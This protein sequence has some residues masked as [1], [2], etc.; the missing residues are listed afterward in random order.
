VG[1]SCLP[2]QRL[3][4]EKEK[5]KKHVC[6]LL[7]YFFSRRLKGEKHLIL[8]EVTARGL[9]GTY[10]HPSDEL[11]IEIPAVAPNLEHRIFLQRTKI[12]HKPKE[13]II[14]FVSLCLF[15]ILLFVCFVCIILLCGNIFCSLAFVCV[16]AFVCVSLSF[17]SCVS[18]T[19]AHFFF[20]ERKQG[21]CLFSL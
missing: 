20:S 18:V 10:V 21:I 12:S 7:Y 4:S 15:V 5:K 2:R 1:I 8:V 6:A 16:C 19:L 11:G 13:C 17:I 9:W 14:V 3:I